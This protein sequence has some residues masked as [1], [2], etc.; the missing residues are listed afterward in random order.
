MAQQKTKPHSGQVIAQVVAQ[1]AGLAV[2]L[3]LTTPAQ[4]QSP[5]LEARVIVQYK[6]EFN[7]LAPMPSGRSIDSMTINA[8][9]MRDLSLRTGMA[10]RSGRHISP[11]SH[12]VVADGLTSDQ[13]VQQ[14]SRQPGV[15][16]VEADRRVRA[17]AVPNDPHYQTVSSSG[18]SGGPVSGQW[19]M[20]APTSLFN[21]SINAERAWDLSTGSS[22]VVVAVLD[23]GIRFDHPDFLHVDSGGNLLNGYDL[24]ADDIAGG[25]S[26]TG[27]DAD[28]SDPGDWSTPEEA[29]QF[30][31]CRASNTSSWH[32]TQ[33][34]GLIGAQTNNNI[35]I[36]SVGQNVKI[37][38][39]R[40]L[41]KCGGDS[42]DIIAGMRWAAGLSVPGIPTNTDPAR[43]LNLSLG[44]SG[45]CSAL[46]A[47]TISEVTAAGAVVVAAAGNSSTSAIGFPANCPGVIAVSAVSHTG[48]KTSYSNLGP[49]NAIAAPGGDGE[50]A[51][52]EWTYPIMSTTNAGTT[53]PE[54][55]GIYTDSFVQVG[56]GTS[57]SAPLVAGT[58][59]LMLSVNASLTPAQVKS[60]LQQ[61]AR[62][63]P[64][65][66]GTSGISQCTATNPPDSA[67]LV[68][69]ECYC[70][71][72]TCGAGMLDAGA[73]VQLV[74]T[75]G[76]ATVTVN[77]ST[78]RAKEAI[79]L[80]ANSSV[81]PSGRT[82]SAYAW[83]IVDGGGIVTA[84]SAGAD[85]ATASITPTASGRF[86][87]RLT[88]T[89][90]LSQQYS[91]IR[92][93]EVEAALAPAPTVSG[94]GSGS[95]SSGGGAVQPYSLLG[96]LMA[97][98]MLLGHRRMNR[99]RE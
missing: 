42:S 23:T 32:G 70:T 64:T 31:S 9:R 93:V 56:L 63:F 92:S 55:G 84:F 87:V 79:S 60:V 11:D 4:A 73:A 43:V 37:L 40:V 16:F 77:Q 19:Y 46:M 38:P 2:M 96:L 30:Q 47:Q 51:N 28:A 3:S 80:S 8:G 72:T 53:T 50:N 82:I 24:I 29:T 17:F 85:T 91:T 10:L 15:A 66:G 14:L 58:A 59:A 62:A 27:R 44:G 12:V 39:V 88:L 5:R 52:G 74:S 75:G 18:G 98:V 1:V 36:A 86:S 33:T 41:G 69:H 99:S 76:L 34:A 89:D 20:R 97:T 65:I 22:S 6:K 61:S 45:S 54:A 95:S 21:A 57:F 67:Q 90:D 49:E 7:R 48:T 81:A 94:S 25:D 68:Q 83:T 35:G 71:T 26:T 78:P 13:L